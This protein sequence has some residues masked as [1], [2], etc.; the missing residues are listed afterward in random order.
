MSCLAT[1]P[2]LIYCNLHSLAEM[3][4]I[5][6]EMFC[7]MISSSLS[8]SLPF[9]ESEASSTVFLV[10]WLEVNLV[11]GRV[12]FEDGFTVESVESWVGG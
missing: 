4:S 9:E 7:L 2:N 12:F 1:L 10:R 5:N 6:L 11:Q 3:K 8:V